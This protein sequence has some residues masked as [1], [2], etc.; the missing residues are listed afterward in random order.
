MARLG[1]LMFKN[2]EALATFGKL[3]R[4]WTAARDKA[5][6]IDRASFI[7]ELA[8]AGL[9]DGEDYELHEEI[10]YVELHRRDRTTLPILL[11]LAERLAEEERG[12]DGSWLAH[13]PG[14]YDQ[15]KALQ[16]NPEGRFHFADKADFDAFVNKRLADYITAQCA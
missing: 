15:L 2:Q 13:A 14:F 11:P 9:L 8:A 4:Q 16:A 10:A 6:R 12:E 7:Q 3:I 5:S 1:E